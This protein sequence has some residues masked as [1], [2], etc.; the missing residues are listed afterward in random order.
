MIPSDGN[1]A[2]EK[3]DLDDILENIQPPSELLAAL[4]EGEIELA[5]PG[6]CTLFTHKIIKYC[7]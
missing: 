5:S 1:M 2:G 3:L 4:K 6:L 7:L